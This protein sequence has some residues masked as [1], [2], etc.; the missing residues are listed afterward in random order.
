MLVNRRKKKEKRRQ[1]AHRR[2]RRRVAG[3]RE[4][5]RLTVFRSNVHLH[6]QVIDD[7]DGVTLVSVSTREKAFRDLGFKVGA[8]VAA[9]EVAGKLLGERARE[10]GISK[11]VFDRG[12]YL[13]HGRVRAAA[14]A[15][16]KS[17][18]EF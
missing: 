5:P 1:A 3:T 16:R 4:R 8:T 17:G 11:I 18:L 10:A 6:L 13:F 9:A 15:A 2:V 14:D 7:G 12:G